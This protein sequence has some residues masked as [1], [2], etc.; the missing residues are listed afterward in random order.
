[1]KIATVVLQI[2]PLHDTYDGFIKKQGE[3]IACFPVKYLTEIGF[4]QKDIDEVTTDWKSDSKKHMDGC[5]GY[6]ISQIPDPARLWKMS[7]F[8]S[9]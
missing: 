6:K 5:L 4:D 2:R 7:N 1:M 8:Q 9:R 3:S